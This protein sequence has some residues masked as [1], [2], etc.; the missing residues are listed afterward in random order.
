M[1]NIPKTPSPY[2]PG[3]DADHTAMLATIGV[4]GFEELVGDIP[5][6]VRNPT[7]D[8]P[9]PLSE[10]ELSAH[11]NE[12]AERNQ[13]A[14]K[15][16]CFLGAGSYRH[17][18][19]AVAR[20]V[21]SRGEFVTAYT[22]YQP[23]AAQGTLQVA[24][25][26]QSLVCELTGLDVANA[27]MY[28]GPTA[29]AEAALMACRLTRRSI[30]AVLNT[31]DPRAVEVLK[32]YTYYQGIRIDV[33]EP[34]ASVLP[35][36]TACLM[37]QSP[38]F[39]GSIEDVASYAEIAHR[40]GSL[41]V[42]HVNPTFLALF[43]SPGEL[44]AD[45]VTA[46]GQPLGVPLTFGGAYV[47]LFAVR[48]AYK[49]QL[50]GR[51]AGRT[52]DTLGRIGYTLT[53]QTREQHIRRETATSN[54]CTSTQ[55]I[56]LMVVAYVAALGRTGLRQ[57]AELCYQKAHY[58]ASEIDRIPGY[59]LATEA[60]FFHEFPIIC[61]KAPA[62]INRRLLERQVVGGLDINEHVT[63]GMLLCATEMNTRSEIEHFLVALRELA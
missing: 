19:P 33:I 39:L 6:S 41:L 25:E 46:E 14:S 4:S 34:T 15:Y 12:L 60:D 22:P 38:N 35:E 52:K 17:H 40:D 42:V 43:K 37:I 28:D 55:L 31:V 27:G 56:G 62:E 11:V 10:L 47:G 53:L 29:F 54:I 5:V 50:P 49:R 57:V 8:L 21:A 44:G 1:N 18:I 20:T 30:V 36:G 63:N 23:E 7:I 58:L 2:M 59:S 61:P 45:I 32:S 3:T 26:F 9:P 51:I 13:S 16:A 24:F 48:E